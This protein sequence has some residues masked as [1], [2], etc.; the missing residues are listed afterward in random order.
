MHVEGT[1][2]ALYWLDIS[3][4]RQKIKYTASAWTVVTR[5]TWNPGVISVG[6]EVSGRA[7]S[8]S[9]RQDRSLVTNHPWATLSNSGAKVDRVN[10]NVFFLA[11]STVGSYVAVVRQV[12]VKAIFVRQIAHDGDRTIV[13]RRAFLRWR[14]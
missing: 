10:N 7:V 3:S 12:V 5:W 14:G 8:D 2:W 11:A 4:D 13:P 6:A 1:F 9:T